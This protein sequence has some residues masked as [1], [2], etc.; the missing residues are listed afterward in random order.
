MIQISS[1][2]R[3]RKKETYH[4]MRKGT[5]CRDNHLG[6]RALENRTSTSHLH[7]E[8]NLTKTKKPIKTKQANDF[9]Q[10][11]ELLLSTILFHQNFLFL[12]TLHA[13]SPHHALHKTHYA[14]TDPSAA[15]STWRTGNHSHIHSPNPTLLPT[16]V[17]FSG[18]RL[19]FVLLPLSQNAVST[20]AC[21][22]VVLC[23]YLIN[24]LLKKQ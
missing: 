22:D 11:T 2:T 15:L 23:L 16:L 10:K 6:H 17:S 1:S 13:P 7:R 12:L 19:F 21:P 4:K 24:L 9:Q 8:N 18:F 20:V 5:R 14:C 3:K